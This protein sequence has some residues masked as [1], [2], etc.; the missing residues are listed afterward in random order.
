MVSDMT[1]RRLIALPLAVAVSLSLAACSGSAHPAG[2]HSANNPIPVVAAENFWGNIAAQIGGS[3]VRVVSIISNPNTDPHEYQSNLQDGV[4]IHK[5]DVV[6]INGAGY[7]GF[8]GKLLSSSGG[9]AAVLTVAKIV[10]VTGSNP[11]PHLWY[12]PSYVDTAATAIEAELAKQEPAGA[13]TFAANLAKFKAA[14]Q[15]QV[16]SVID[17][18]KAKYAGDAI[19]YTERVPGYLIQQAGLHLGTPA[20]FSQA[21]EDGSTPSPADNAAFEGAITGHKVKVLLYNSQVTDAET[22]HLKQL[23]ASSGVPVVGVAETMP[24]SA[25]NF[26]T[27]QADQARELLKALGG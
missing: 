18:I 15:S 25:A 11:N 19:A 14:E 22:V 20:S 5:A 24:P 17:E 9:G 26:Q 10:H 23:A 7:D 16:V 12:D 8:M 1:S 6:I 21:V 27:W 4:A 13:S 3:L 2:Q